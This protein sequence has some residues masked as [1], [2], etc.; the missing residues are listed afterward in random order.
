MLKGFHLTLLIGPAIPVPAMQEVMEALQDIEVQTSSG[1][2]SGFKLTFALGKKSILNTTLL[3][4]GYFDPP[5]RVIIVVTINGTPNV[6]M[7]GV[8]TQHTVTPSNE[9][10]QSTLTI[11]GEDLSRM[12]DIFEIPG[13]PYLGMSR[14]VRAAVIIAKYASLGIVPLVIP[15]IAPDVPLPTEMIPG[16][17]GTDLQYITSLADQVGYV[18]YIEPGPMPSANVAYWGPEIKVGIP[19]PYLTVNMDAHNNVD[20]LSFTFDGFAKSLYSIKIRDPH[21]CLSISIPIPDVNPLSPPLGLKP[22]LPLGLKEIDG[23]AKYPPVQAVMMGMAK[24]SQHADVISGTG[25]LNVLRYG[26][27]LKAR[28]LVEVR[29]AGLTY[30]GLYYVESVTHNIKLGEY[31]QNFTLRRNASIPFSKQVIA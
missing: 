31:K 18:F 17:R 8:I 22:P 9:P 13:I 26:Q 20:S 7:D 23:M 27:I 15:S 30:D 3:P 16:H 6:L 25:S 29:G 1:M 19:Q 24:A 5:M 10:G 14:E 4:V 11:M 28:Q 21:S 12:M 2:R